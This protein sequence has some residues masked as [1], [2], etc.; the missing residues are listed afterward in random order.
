VAERGVPVSRLVTFVAAAL[1]ALAAAAAAA[2]N[3]ASLQTTAIGRTPF[4]QRAFVL[5]LPRAGSVGARDVT[6]TENGAPVTDISL[7]PL[8]ASGLRYG[9]VLALDASD[10]MAGAPFASALDAARSF[11]AKRAEGERIALLAF[12]GSLNILQAPTLDAGAL[13]GSLAHPPALSYGTRIVD[14]VGASL[15]LL[16]QTKVSAGAVV[17]LSD[18][19]D[20][21]SHGSLARVLAQARAQHVRVFTVALRSASLDRSLLQAIAQAT[22]GTYSETTSTRGLA[23]VYAAL[24]QRLASEYVLEYRSTA[25]PSSHV[26]VAISVAGAG[27]SHARYTSPTQSGLQPFHR[28]LLTRFLLS[29]VSLAFLSLLVAG[30][31][32]WTLHLLIERTRPRIVERVEA[33]VGSG[34]PA[35]SRPRGRRRGAGAAGTRNARGWLAR[36]EQDLEIARIEIPAGRVVI[37]VTAVTL[38]LGM[39]LALISPV[40]F[41]LAL[42]VPLAARTLIGRKLRNVRSEFAEQLPPNLQILASALRAGHSFLGA[43]ASSVDNAHEPSRSELGRV[44]ADERLGVPTDEAIRRVAVR[45]ESRDLEQVALLA[46]LARTTGGNSAE[47]LDTVVQTIRERADVRRLVRTLTAQG[48]MARWILTGLP[49]VTGFGFYLIQPAVMAPMLHSIFGQVLL[50][51]AAA[52]VAAGSFAIQRI[53]DIEI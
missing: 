45:M 25:A 4:P 14:A 8:A 36:L 12:N 46:E 43:F 2:A 9:V 40:L 3:P 38:A 11:I 27:V 28:S 19:A 33:F 1:A 6:V 39:L 15:R 30:L 53:V 42:L 18:G 52:M 20:V 35:A 21:G 49:V 22:G 13:A 24:G 47:V 16:A 5:D 34:A 7:R 44:L 17:L 51:A 32:G 29:W 41:L 23:P 50:V 48:R 10:S 26:D 31:A 37:G